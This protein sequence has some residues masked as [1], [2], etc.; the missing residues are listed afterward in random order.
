[1]GHRSGAGRGG[2]ERA[3]AVAG[4]R[5]GAR[6][7]GLSLQR[8]RTGIAQTAA[9]LIV[10]HGITDWSLA[11]RKAARTLGLPDSVQLPAND[12]I[13]QALAQHH[14][15][16]GGT[17]HEERLR[18][19]RS[20]ALHWMHQLEAFA[21]LLVGGVAAGWAT[22]HSDIRLELT[23]DDPKTVEI[24]LAGAGIRYA[25]TAPADD[26]TRPSGS[27]QLLISTSRDRI[28]LVVLTPSQRRNRS[29]R[30]DETRLS[31]SDVAAL[32]AATD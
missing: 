12:E 14:A 15:L 21:P 23:A 7:D 8:Q 13:E 25:V 1:M 24:V 28:R 29:R 2:R 17:A 20:A 6:P 22:E 32:L 9:R 11:K 3:R 30:D 26:E 4:M 10:E 16:F 31:R 27:V 19:Q 5:D 18:L